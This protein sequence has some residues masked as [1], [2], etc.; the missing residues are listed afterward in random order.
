MN[1][2]YCIGVFLLV[3]AVVLGAGCT[4]PENPSNS[5]NL[6]V[7]ITNTI[8][9][10]QGAT[11]QTKTVSL[12]PT[13]KIY[14]QGDYSLFET[15]R[16]NFKFMY[17]KDWTAYQTHFSSDYAP[18]DGIKFVGKSATLMQEFS[19]E[20]IN[21][22]EQR[23]EGDVV[24]DTLFV[25]P[26]S[27]KNYNLISNDKTTIDRIPATKL[28]YQYTNGEMQIKEMTVILLKDNIGIEIKY[29]APVN[30][31]NSNINRIQN[32]IDSFTF[33]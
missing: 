9:P 17:P 16:I 15:P 1:T 27:Y 12:S 25:N 5:G 3:V 7:S 33:Y 4:Q 20:V 6:Q 29:L 19:V 31:Y 18:S 26:I 28:V 30:D 21:Y 23:S 8:I 2:F 32:Y 22:Q 14:S 24:N 11:T 13:P 10:S